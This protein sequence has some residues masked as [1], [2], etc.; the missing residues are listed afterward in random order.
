MI[1]QAQS[2]D[3]QPPGPGKQAIPTERI[4]SARSGRVIRVLD[5]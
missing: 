2:E 5:T 1:D 4:R 3:V